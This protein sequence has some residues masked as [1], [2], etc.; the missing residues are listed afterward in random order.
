MERKREKQLGFIGT[1]GWGGKRVG[2]GRPNLS[3]QINHM[4]RPVM[5]IKTPIHITLRLREC[6]PSIRKKRL[7]KEFKE[8]V[9]RAKNFGLYVI[10]FSIQRN[11]IHLFCE[12]QSN[13]AVALGMRALAGRFAK[14][15]RG[16]SYSNGYG[17]TGSVF[18]GRYH[19]H[20]LKTPGEVRNA[21]E[22]V[23][24]NLSKHQ[25]LIEYLDSFS[26]GSCF[27]QWPK[28][29]GKRFESLIKAEAEFYAAQEGPSDLISVLSVPQSW[30]AQT[31]WMKACG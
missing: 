5:N 6:L 10:H 15:I 28:L 13:K 4:K 12:G 20:V 23:L 18:K 24:L 2:S 30:L 1:T 8:S 21:L 9:K 3:G 17:K 25:K 7:L 29:L 26:S 19:L 14:I 16:Y 31:G 11:H 22:Y 27:R